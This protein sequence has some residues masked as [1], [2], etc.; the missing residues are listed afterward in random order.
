[1][2]IFQV[3]LLL[4]IL[5]SCKQDSPDSLTINQKPSEV[6][7]KGSKKSHKET[8]A[9]MDKVIAN[10]IKSDS[11]NVKI[12]SKL[13]PVINPK[14]PSIFGDN[15]I[16]NIFPASPYSKVAIPKVKITSMTRNDENLVGFLIKV[17]PHRNSPRVGDKKLVFT[18]I[19]LSDVDCNSNFMS[20]PYYCLGNSY[21]IL[22]FVYDNNDLRTAVEALTNTSSSGVTLDANG[23]PVINSH[24]D[25]LKYGK[26]YG[27]EL[28]NFKIGLDLTNIQFY[29]KLDSIDLT[30]LSYNELK[31]LLKYNPDFIL[32][33]GAMLDYGTIGTRMQTAS[34]FTWKLEP[35]N[36]NIMTNSTSLYTPFFYSGQSMPDLPLT[37]VTEPC[38]P[39][40]HPTQ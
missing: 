30:F 1:M 38:P 16:I 37:A 20:S 2:K 8:K 5:F 23:R 6:S 12:D 13:I 11:K 33:S 22:K 14:L 7:T 19:E 39:F 3:L 31:I 10:G 29:E 21:E 17:E 35:V 25:L 40:W 4:V 24:N 9:K 26:K 34:Y 15:G 32:L 36:Q 18:R 27:E 28:S